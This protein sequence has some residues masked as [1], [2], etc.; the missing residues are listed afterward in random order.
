MIKHAKKIYKV[1]WNIIESE[2]EQQDLAQMSRYQQLYMA[3]E[4]NLLEIYAEK[5][6]KLQVFKRG[7][8]ISA[9]LFEAS[10]REKEFELNFCVALGL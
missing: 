1:F 10:F 8:A 9:K 5:G 4:L 6:E 7:L 3:N 2:E